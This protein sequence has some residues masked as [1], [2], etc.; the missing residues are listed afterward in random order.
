[1]KALCFLHSILIT[2]NNKFNANKHNKIIFYKFVINQSQVN[3]KLRQIR[4]GK[5]ISQQ[6]IAS[7]LNISQSQYCRKEAN[8]VGFTEKEW[9]TI[10]EF[11][12][13][14]LERIKDSDSK[15]LFQYNSTDKLENIVSLSEKLF[16]ELKEHNNT[17]KEIIAFQKE[18]ISEL[19][20]RL[21]MISL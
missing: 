3:I 6:K 15:T 18:E 16:Q 9:N 1:M 5:N 2:K 14:D 10:A 13:T 4:E 19:K 7:E 21:K 8:I 12:Q 17:L 11:L 20:D